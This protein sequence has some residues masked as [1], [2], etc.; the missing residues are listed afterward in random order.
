MTLNELAAEVNQTAHTKGWYLN[1]NRTFGDV[2]ALVHSEL[3]EALEE[4][5]NGRKLGLLYAGDKV[6][7]NDKDDVA[8]LETLAANGVKPEGVA[9]EL[10]D[11]IIRVLDTMHEV[12][13]DIDGAMRVKMAYNET[14]PYKHGGKII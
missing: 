4:Y 12:G 9:I 7:G 2:I 6:F 8:V 13:I 3:S 5:R 1:T 11:V 14:R 10:I